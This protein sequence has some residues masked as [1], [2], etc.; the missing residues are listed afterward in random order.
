MM[1]LWNRER[2]FE[3]HALLENHWHDAQGEWREV[4]KTLIQAA[5]VYVH[6]EAGRAVAAAKM[7]PRVSGRLDALRAHLTPIVNLDTLCRALA[8]P[9]GRPPRLEGNRR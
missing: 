9:E 1:V 6:R 8:R 2:F 7:G 4:L 5:A 3:V